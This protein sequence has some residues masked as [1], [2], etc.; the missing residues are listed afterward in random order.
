MLR[1]VQEHFIMIS[2]KVRILRRERKRSVSIRPTVSRLPIKRWP[3]QKSSDLGEIS[4]VTVRLGQL[5]VSHR[6]T[7]F[8]SFVYVVPY[9]AK[10]K[11]ARPIKHIVFAELQ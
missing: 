10:T 11:N 4:A 9:N 5:S 7:H 2:S 1:A 6:Q 8:Q 3:I